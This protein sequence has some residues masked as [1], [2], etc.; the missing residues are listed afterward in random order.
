MIDKVFDEDFLDSIGVTVDDLAVDAEDL[1]WVY[2]AGADTPDILTSEEFESVLQAIARSRTYLDDVSATVTELDDY[3]DD[4]NATPD[5]LPGL[6]GNLKGIH[7]ELE[8]CQR[9]NELDDGLEYALSPET[10]TPDVD[11]FGYDVG[12]N[13]VRKIQVKITENPEYIRDAL[14]SLPP[15][16]Q[17]ISGTEMAQLFPDRVL[18]LG[19]SA[20]E[21]L[22]D[23][24]ETVNVLRSQEPEF[25]ELS[26][27]APFQEYIREAGI[28]F[29]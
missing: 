24:E 12:G 14:D 19:L 23:V 29:A 27:S 1:E 4:F 5:R 28:A 7:G 8:V 21:V 10:N 11:I 20:K 18:D 2:D 22:E 26:T 6:I 13:V 25:T 9:L 16:V 15:D 17:V 3:V